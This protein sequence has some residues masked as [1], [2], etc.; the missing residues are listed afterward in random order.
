[1]PTEEKLRAPWLLAVWPGMGG[2]AISAG[3]VL[4]AKPGTH[5]LFEFPTGELFDLGQV[6]IKES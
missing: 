1:M 4:M 6:E 2:V 3:Y 5:L